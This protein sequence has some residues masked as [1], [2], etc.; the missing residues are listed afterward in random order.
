M[1][2][3][4]GGKEISAVCGRHKAELHVIVVWKAELGSG[5]LGSSA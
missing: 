5:E 2:L 1:L 3:E 4:T